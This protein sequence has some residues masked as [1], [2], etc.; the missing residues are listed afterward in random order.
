[1]TIDFNNK[2]FLILGAGLTG[3][4]I[5][6]YLATKKAFISIVDDYQ[7][8]VQLKKIIDDTSN[9]NLIGKK[10]LRFL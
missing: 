8:V 3:V 9:I 4:S 7:T 5:A 2:K 10:L 6:R 1:M